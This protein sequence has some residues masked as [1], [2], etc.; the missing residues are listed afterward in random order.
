MTT[1]EYL[2]ARGWRQHHFYGDRWVKRGSPDAA[3]YPILEAYDMQR[4]ADEHDAIATGSVVYFPTD[5]QATTSA[6]L[7]ACHA[8]GVTERE[9]IEHL[10][11]DNARLLEALVKVTEKSPP[12][13]VIDLGSKEPGR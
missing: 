1:Q 11:R 3:L 5:E 10:F 13:I 2:R 7:A 4:A 8:R 9:V 12:A 6:L